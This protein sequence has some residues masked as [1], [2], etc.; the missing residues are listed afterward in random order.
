V[1]ASTRANQ[2]ASFSNYGATTVDIAAPGVSIY[3][4]TPRNTY[5]TFSGTSMAT[6]HVSAV[7]AL[8]WAVK[9]NATVAEVRSA[10][11][12]GADRLSSLSGKLVSGEL[13]AYNTLRL[14]GGQAQ[15]GPTVGSLTASPGSVTAGAT[16]TLGAHGIAG[17]AGVTS[18]CFALDVNNDGQISGSDTVLG[19][20]T[21]I[22]G[23]EASL[24]LGTGKYAA[25][26]YHFL[27]R[28]QDSKGQWSAW[29]ATTLTILAA[30]DYGNN[31]A[32]A[33][34]IAV[35]SSVS[36]KLETAGDVDWFKFQATAGKS[37]VFTVGLGTLRDSILYL[38]DTNGQKQLVVND[39]YGG[40]LASQISWTAKTSGTYYVA[41]AGY[42]NKY[43]GSYTLIAELKGAAAT[44]KASASDL[45]AAGL[46]WLS[47]QANSLGRGSGSNPG[48]TSCQAVAQ[49]P[50]ALTA[51][52]HDEVLAHLSSA[53]I[54]SAP[55]ESALTL[56]QRRLGPVLAERYE[57]FDGSAPTDHDA[58]DSVFD[59]LAENLCRL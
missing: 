30:D 43:A 12:Q 5:S 22:A 49:E 7:A 59:L 21:K 36:G 10:I 51:S 9:P 8:A 37:Y 16:I 45:S 41:V 47:A 17:S 23:G 3:S 27:A 15:Q 14:L 20:T 38:Y 56:L 54:S 46:A 57:G 13:N 52:L 25:G 42:G 48:G 6:P 50:L 24:A 11:L 35:P 28:A 39:D 29:T 1:A 58:I 34:P 2:L 26:T 32:A 18:V 4:T 53:D 44:A 19:T 40:K 31:A 33:A 55:W